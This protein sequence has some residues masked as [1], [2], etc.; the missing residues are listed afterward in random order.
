MGAATA[1]EQSQEEGKG[2]E[3]IARHAAVMAGCE[4]RFSKKDVEYSFCPAEPDQE[5][6]GRNTEN[7]CRNA[8]YNRIWCS[9]GARFPQSGKNKST[10]LRF[11]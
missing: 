9:N 7:R 11:E 10:L 1:V 3:R 4:R 8:S 2:K 5:L 6:K